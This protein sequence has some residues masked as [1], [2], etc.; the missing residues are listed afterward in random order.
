MICPKLNPNV[1][2]YLLKLYSWHFC[3]CCLSIK[4]DMYK[5]YHHDRNL[6]V[7][8]CFP[9]YMADYMICCIVPPKNCVHGSLSIMM[10]S[11]NGN[12]FRVTDHLC[13]EFT[14]HRWIL[15]QRPVTRSFDVFFDL[16]LNKRLR[17]QSWGWWFEMQSRPLWRHWNDYPY[18]PELHNWHW[19]NHM[20][21]S[22]LKQYW[23]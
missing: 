11:S 14:D 8:I 15:A 17:K 6:I 18:S 23:I 19:V 4:S 20:M 7:T 3:L 1:I 16:R 9:V 2:W 12:I 22:P 5:R 10:T 13:G 21:P